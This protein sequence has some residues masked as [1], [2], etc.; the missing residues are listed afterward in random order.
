MGSFVANS[1]HRNQFPLEQ[2][3]N[4]PPLYPQKQYRSSYSF[5][6][7]LGHVFRFVISMLSFCVKPDAEFS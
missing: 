6:T 7:L 4:L 2:F 1:S 5:Y 3:S